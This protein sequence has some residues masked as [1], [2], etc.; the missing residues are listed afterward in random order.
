MTVVTKNHLHENS[1]SNN[2]HAI[3]G[4]EN[5]TIQSYFEFINDID[6]MYKQRMGDSTELPKFIV[7]D[8][9]GALYALQ[10]CRKDPDFFKGCISI[11][12]LFRFATP[13][14]VA[15]LSK[16]SL[17]WQK[18]SSKGEPKTHDAMTEFIPEQLAKHNL[19]GRSDTMSI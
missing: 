9:L 16:M 6:Q 18:M 13:Y 7:G 2:Q 15:G 5:D 19:H 1:S 11:N 12:P 17:V 3:L 14:Q 4:K 8:G 10:A